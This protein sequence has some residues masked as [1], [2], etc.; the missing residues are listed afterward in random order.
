MSNANVRW[1]VTVAV[2]LLLAVSVG[3]TEG[4]DG[5]KGRAGATAPVVRADAPAHCC[6]TNPRYVGTCDVQPATEETCSSILDYLN[7][8]Q[9]Q[10]KTYCGNTSVRGDWKAAACEAKPS[11]D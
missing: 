2:G 5:Q 11:G 8:S 4:S 7:N 10:G 3:G 6:F 1:A 9:S